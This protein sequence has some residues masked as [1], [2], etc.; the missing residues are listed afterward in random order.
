VAQWNKKVTDVLI[1]SFV[2]D[3]DEHEGS[4]PFL[5][6]LLVSYLKVMKPT[7]Y[8]TMHSNRDGKFQSICFHWMK[9]KWFSWWYAWSSKVE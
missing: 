1:F 8:F 3:A 2:L 9:K 6:K 7:T 4:V 5:T